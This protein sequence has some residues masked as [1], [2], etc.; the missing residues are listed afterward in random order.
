MKRTIAA[1]LSLTVSGCSLLFTHGPGPVGKPPQTYARCTDSNTL[2]IVDAVIGGVL[3]LSALGAFGTTQDG[4]VSSDTADQGTAATISGLLFA[5]LFGVSAFVGVGRTKKCRAAHQE[6]VAAHPPPMQPIGPGYVP[7][8]NVPVGAQGGFCTAQL[9]C[10][11]GLVCAGM[12]DHT[13]RCMQGHIVPVAP[14]PPAIGVQGG[15]CTA[16]LTC[17]PGL[18]CAG[19]PD[20]TNKCMPSRAPVPPSPPSIGMQG[21]ACTAQ[22]TC[23]TGLVCAGMPDRSNKC[24]PAPSPGTHGGACMANNAC[25]A[26]LMCAGMPDHTNKCMPAQ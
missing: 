10:D 22:L 20:H 4:D 1:V 17:D 6:Y 26:G 19:M 14:P 9:G 12:P 25:N 16:Q 11:P 23:N 13:N 24:V 8:Q 7:Q 3:L 15:A 18:Q 5:G 21:G 2:P